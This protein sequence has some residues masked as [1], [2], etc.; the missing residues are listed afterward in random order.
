MKI[1]Y[2]WLQDFI[3]IEE[4]PE[5]LGEVLTQTGLEVEGIETV[6]KVKGGLQGLVVGEVISCEKHPDADKLNLTTVDIGQDKLLSIVCGAPNVAA[7]QKVVVAPINTTIFPTN[8]EPFKIK[9]AKIR[10]QISEGMIC[11][12]DEIG[13]GSKHDGIIVLDTKVNNGTPASEL[14]NI[15]KDSIFEIGL[16]PNRGDA[17]S[18]WGTARD[19]RAYFKREISLPKINLPQR[20]TDRPVK[21]IVEDDKGCI[22]Y[23]G[24]TI[25]DIKVGP[26]P[27]WLQ[28]KLR[29]IG[30]EPINNIVDITNYVL[31]SLGQPLHAF[32]ADKIRGQK[33]IVKTLPEGTKFTTL[34]EKERKLSANDLMICDD[35]GGMCIAGVFGGIHSGVKDSTTS[36]F[37]ESA[38]FSPDY[39]RASAQ[40]HGLSTDASF[41]F[42]RSTDPEDTI[43]ALEYAA[44]LILDLAGGFMA[45]DTIDIYPKPVEPVSIPTSTSVFRR[46]IGEEIPTHQIHEILNLLDIQTSEKGESF[47][48]IVPPYRSEVT[49][50]ADLVEEVLRIYG[51]NKIPLEDTFSSDYLAEFQ[52]KEPYKLQEELSTFLAGNGFNEILTN[53]LTNKIY[54]EELKLSAET[55]VEMLNHSSEELSVLKASPLYTG[56]EVIRHNLNR[57]QENLRLFEFNKSYYVNVDYHEDEWLSLYL[58]GHTHETSWMSEAGEF[59]FHHLMQYLEG[60]LDWSGISEVT[61]IPSQQSSTFQYALDLSLNNVSLG[62]IGKLKHE[63]LSYYDINQDVFY[64]QLDWK[65]L[66]RYTRKSFD[67]RPI[68]KYPEVRRD[69]S[70]ILNKAITFDSI[71]KIAFN[72]EK[73]L[74]N[75]VNVFSIYEGQSIGEGKKAYAISFYLRDQ[76]KTLTDKQ[77]DKV[78]NHL[79]Q[80][81]E[82]ELGAI[83]RK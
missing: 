56:L 34:D 45:S 37:L 67:F 36:I 35:Q 83:I 58:T 50:E 6:E 73:K 12:E 7:S 52:E 38:C 64:L 20:K 19:L 71:Q 41:R 25:R 54:Q 66:Q 74:L 57:R 18:H 27:D 81:F 26:S 55:S 23:S 29:A 32:D 75:R 60:I 31:H 39:I 1:S 33:V 51:F 8:G 40:R 80:L 48:A 9:K 4:P 30:Q 2:N 11:A 15:G 53:S 43:F 70:L 72:S 61:T 59:T 13:L 22:R 76:T 69:L 3:A 10:G 49:R 68:S 82:R 47:S 78:M 77:I 44:Q 46:L 65:K 28:W 14:F 17:T 63:M 42:E 21:V 62:S 79:M 16:T 24:M 5:M